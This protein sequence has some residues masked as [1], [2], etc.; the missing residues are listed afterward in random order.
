MRDLVS[1]DWRFYGYGVEDFDGLNL[2]VDD[3]VAVIEIEEDQLVKGN[4]STD[5]L[6]GVVQSGHEDA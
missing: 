6:Y 1:G 2:I 3:G 5:K 4:Y